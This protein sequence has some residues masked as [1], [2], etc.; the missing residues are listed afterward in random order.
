MVL[1]DQI[2]AYITCGSS[3]YTERSVKLF[4]NLVQFNA[5][6]KPVVRSIRRVRTRAYISVRQPVDTNV[7]AELEE[8]EIEF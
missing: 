3:L 1:Y 2:F 4:I 6:D 8:I 7:L 5:E